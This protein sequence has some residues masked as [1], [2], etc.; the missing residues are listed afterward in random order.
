MIEFLCDVLHKVCWHGRWQ[1]HFAV[2]FFCQGLYPQIQRRTVGNR[3]R[4]WT[5]NG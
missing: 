3:F 4:P 2:R 5:P 1:T